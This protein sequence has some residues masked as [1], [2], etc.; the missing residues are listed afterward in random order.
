MGNSRNRFSQMVHQAR[1]TL[2]RRFLVKL[3]RASHRVQPAQLELRPSRVL[4]VAPHMDDEAI[5]C[6]GTLLRHISIGSAVHVVFVSDSSAGIPDKSIAATVTAQRKLEA[7]R[8]MEKL[9]HATMSMLDFPDGSLG[10]HEAAITE[11][12]AHELQ[13]FRPDTVLVPFPA[14][15]HSDHMV[16]AVSTADALRKSRWDGTVLAY[17]V[18]APL[19]ATAYVNISDFAEQ[20]RALIEV[21]E[22][23]QA[24]R[25]YA[26]AILGLNR[27]RGLVHRVDFAEAFHACSS[28]EFAKLVAPLNTL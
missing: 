16:C 3:K 7:H 4:V 27:Y 5:A 21:Y 11:K 9:G 1:V 2:L 6:G 26:S 28:R 12:I 18:W 25:D 20:K 22:S 13:S 14:D 15:S 23:Q 10:S 19:W 24:D 17:E 8:S